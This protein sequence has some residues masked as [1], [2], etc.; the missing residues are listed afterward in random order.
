MNMVRKSALYL[1]SSIDSA[2]CLEMLTRRHRFEI[3]AGLVAFSVFPPFADFLA[4]VSLM[5]YNLLSHLPAVQQLNGYR[6]A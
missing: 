4:I 3:L 6:A 1:A 5:P 2:S